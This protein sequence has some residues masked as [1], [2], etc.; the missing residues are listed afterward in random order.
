MY[1]CVGGVYLQHPAHSC[2]VGDSKYTY[3][4]STA[5]CLRIRKTQKA[6]V[7]IWTDMI[8]IFIRAGMHSPSLLPESS[9]LKFKLRI[10]LI[11]MLNSGH[12]Y[13]R[14]IGMKRFCCNWI[15]SLLWGARISLQTQHDPLRH[16]AVHTIRPHEV[17]CSSSVLLFPLNHI[18]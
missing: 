17:I 9:S 8:K 16:T 10:K 5:L 7:K 4:S 18:L 3:R 14:S 12:P 1:Y 15:S 2:A 6:R 13:L 11:C